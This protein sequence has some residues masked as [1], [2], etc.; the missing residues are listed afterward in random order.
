MYRRCLVTLRICFIV[1]LSSI[2]RSLL[3]LCIVTCSFD[4]IFLFFARLRTLLS[5]PKNCLT[6]KDSIRLINYKLD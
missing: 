6:E 4:T 1:F 3:F 5:L 2:L